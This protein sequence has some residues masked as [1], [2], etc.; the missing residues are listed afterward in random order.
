MTE[1][2][3]KT[4]VLVWDAPVRVFHWL[5]VL[6]FAGAYLTA[7]SE[8]WR[9]V[10][11]SLGYT[12][13]GLVAFRILWG[14]MGTRHARFASFVRGPAAVLRYVRVMLAGRPEHHVGHN[15]AGALAIVLLLLSSIAIVATGW[16]VYNDVGGDWLG[17]LHEG[18]ANFMLIVVAVHVAGVAVASWLHRENLV[19]AMVTGKKEGTPDTGIRRAWRPLALVMLVAVLGFWWLQWQSAP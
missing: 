10:H 13:G 7:E 17:D 8:R 3:T 15:P 11:V 16:A 6:S 4:Q 2:T 5:L 18:A 9:L 1:S 14:L 19:R 12:L